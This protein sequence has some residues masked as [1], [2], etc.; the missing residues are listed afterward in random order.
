M[1]FKGLEDDFKKEKL[2]P[3]KVFLLHVDNEFKKDK[4][5]KCSIENLNIDTIKL[6]EE[7]LPE[8]EKLRKRSGGET[9]H[10]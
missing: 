4:V 9:V 5:M 10:R 8:L 2:T 1:L 3:I 6:I 7:K